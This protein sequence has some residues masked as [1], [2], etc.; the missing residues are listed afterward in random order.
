MGGE[1]ENGECELKWG[2]GGG[3]WG[4][5]WGCERVNPYRI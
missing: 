5:G 2:W 3:G 1:K 4:W